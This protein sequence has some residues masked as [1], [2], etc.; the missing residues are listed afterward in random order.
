MS[1]IILCP[2]CGSSDIQKITGLGINHQIE[3]VCNDC[4]HQWV[5]KAGQTGRE[6][7]PENDNKSGFVDPTDRPGI[8]D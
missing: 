6:I 4:R 3:A 5:I 1:N 2:K 7:E 8:D